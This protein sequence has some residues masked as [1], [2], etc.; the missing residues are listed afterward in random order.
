MSDTEKLPSSDEE[1]EKA[2][3]PKASVLSLLWAEESFDWVYIFTGTL[4]GLITGFSIPAFNV[5]FGLM[6]DALNEDDDPDFQKQIEFIAVMFV[7]IASLNLFTGYFQ[8]VGWSYFGELKTQRI[9]EKYVHA[10]L[11]QEIGWFDSCGANELS[12]R[13][14]DLAG[15]VQDGTGRKVG[16]L[17][18]Y[19]AQVLG[20]FIVGFY[21]NWR[22]TLV[23]LT[24]YPLIGAAG[25]FMINA[26][27]DAK[28]KSMEQYAAAG[29]IATEALSSIRTVT[30]LNIQPQ[31]IAEYRKMIYD[32]MLV[33]ITKGLKVG[34]GHG[35][36]FCA[37]FLTYGLGFW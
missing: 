20:S 14:A 35:G 37:A 3:L 17:I 11:S 10:I 24:A 22:L 4:G 8:V 34:M 30:A 5:L 28:N 32:A 12:T 36:V 18:Q 13:V 25:A 15:K 19:T 26:V 31:I 9:R 6:L 21:L 1:A 27:T 16:D 23:L 33:G 2:D 29:G 7:I